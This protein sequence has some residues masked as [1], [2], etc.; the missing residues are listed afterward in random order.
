M[1]LTISRVTIPAF[2]CRP[3]AEA[4]ASLIHYYPEIE[5]AFTLDDY[6]SDGLIKAMQAD[7]RSRAVKNARRNFALHLSP[8]ATMQFV[9]G[10]LR[11]PDGLLVDRV[12]FSTPYSLFTPSKLSDM[13]NAEHR[14]RHV[15]STTA[16]TIGAAY[17]V[18]N[19]CSAEICF[20]DARGRFPENVL[21]GYRVQFGDMY[22]GTVEQAL[23]SIERIM[24]WRGALVSIG[25]SQNESIDLDC[26][27]AMP[28]VWEF[29]ELIKGRLASRNV[30]KTWQEELARG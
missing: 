19:R 4:I 12:F 15:I 11:L 18:A 22:R 13:L 25:M 6:V 16:M 14:Y 2:K 7:V 17:E 30:S 28:R 20:S 23:V 21:G 1:P 27:L 29:M 24:P 8:L 5:F 9:D 3:D 26:E 10:E